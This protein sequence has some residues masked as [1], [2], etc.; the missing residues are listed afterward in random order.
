MVWEL[1]KTLESVVPNRII[2]CIDKRSTPYSFKVS[3]LWFLLFTLPADVNHVFCENLA[4]A[5]LLMWNVK[6]YKHD[7]VDTS[8]WKR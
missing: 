3:M 4:L 8:M 5:L 2:L 1:Q 6:F 7:Q